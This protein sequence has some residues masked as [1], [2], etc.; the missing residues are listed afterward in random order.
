[1]TSRRLLLAVTATL[2]IVSS[3]ANAFDLENNSGWH[4]FNFGTVGYEWNEFFEFD[5]D[6][7]AELLVTDAYLSGDRFE[8]LINEM[9]R[10]LTSA[11]TSI[12]ADA[13]NMFDFAYADPRWSSGHYFLKPGSYTVSGF[14]IESPYQGGPAA[15]QLR[16]VSSVPEPASWAMMLLGLVAVG[17]FVRRRRDERAPTVVA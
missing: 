10:G 14:V 6:S 5:L 16:S 4:E 17:A 12:E 3:P 11:P 7:P 2:A 1:M 9:S 13:G 15:I 8:V